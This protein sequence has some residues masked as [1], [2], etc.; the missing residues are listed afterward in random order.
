MDTF[1]TVCLHMLMLHMP[2]SFGSLGSHVDR[3]RYV[4]MPACD[5]FG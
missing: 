2:K 3:R 1:Y 4:F 5:P